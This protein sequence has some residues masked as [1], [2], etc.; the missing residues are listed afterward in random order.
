MPKTTNW[1]KT[2]NTSRENPVYFVQEIIGD[3]LWQKQ[4]EIMQSVL[5]G[6]TTVASCHGIGKSFTAARVVLH[7][8]SCF[9]GTIGITTAP[10]NRQVEKILWKE[11]RT[12]HKR[13]KKDL[14]GKM[15]L[16]EWK[17]D[18]DWFAFGF[19]TDD[20]DQF[21]GFHAKR[22]LVV[23]DEAAGVSEDIFNG[24]D[25]VLSGDNCHQLYIGNPTS[26]SGRFYQS[27][28]ATKMAES[29]N[30]YS[31]SAFDTP[32]FTE[33][34]ITYE[35]IKNDT[36][37]KKITGKLP[38]PQL[39]TPQWV[40]ARYI[41]W[42]PQSP[43]FQAKVLGIFPENAEDTIV[44]V[45]LW[46]Q[47]K[48]NESKPEDIELDD[49]M[50]GVDPARFGDDKTGVAFKVQ[51]KLLKLKQKGGM[52]T[53]KVSNWI[54]MQIKNTF[55]GLDNLKSIPINVDAIGIGAGVA[56]QLRNILDYK[57]VM[58][59][60]SSEKAIESDRF[61]NKRT[62]MMWNIRELLKDKAMELAM[63]DEQLEN[64]MTATRYDIDRSGRIKAESKKEVKKRLGES[65][66]K[67]DAVCMAFYNPQKV[68]DNPRVRILGA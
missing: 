66:D 24:I 50:I 10:T 32:N 53:T 18:D 2:I 35:D 9:P 42:G 47:A 68:S 48:I 33:F 27:H 31:I 65:P 58:D 44:P 16:K 3:K 20:T 63:D 14:G 37:G 29:F 45:Y 67:A 52:D 15:L 6:D 21:Q 12:A 60:K 55:V 51:N 25:G 19:S 59:I 28:K 17:L 4:K 7:Q 26:L 1:L 62:E 61:F 11:I 39:V 49:I 43:L 34:G 13:S 22:I 64:Q 36:W 56:D 41:A 40:Y 5:E 23:V 54:D 46:K 57:N 38:F 30:R 8:V